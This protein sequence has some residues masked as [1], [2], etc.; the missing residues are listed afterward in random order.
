MFSLGCICVAYFSYRKSTEN[1]Q[2]DLQDG[3]LSYIMEETCTKGIFKQKRQNNITQAV[4]GSDS[5][6]PRHHVWFLSHAE[7][8]CAGHLLHRGDIRRTL[9]QRILVFYVHV[10]FTFIL[11]YFILFKQFV[12]LFVGFVV[13][14][15]QDIMKQAPTYGWYLT[16]GRVSFTARVHTNTILYAV[17]FAD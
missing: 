16:L 8:S 10:Y 12:V 17:V 14:H 2:I 11:R 7:P 13:W 1:P 9:L 6:C 3:L 15:G 4:P 5:A